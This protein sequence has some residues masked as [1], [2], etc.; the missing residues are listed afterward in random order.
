MTFTAVLNL[1]TN[2]INA[3]YAENKLKTVGRDIRVDVV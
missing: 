1:F 2:V 3:L